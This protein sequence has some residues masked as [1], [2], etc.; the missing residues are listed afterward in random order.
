MLEGDGTSGLGPNPPVRDGEA[1]LLGLLGDNLLLCKEEIFIVVHVVIGWVLH[2]HP[3][4][5]RCLTMHLVI[6]LEVWP[7]GQP[8]PQQSAGDGLDAG[9]HLHGAPPGGSPQLLS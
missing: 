5:L 4:R 9:L 1:E 8:H 3:G 7:D 2:P 6:P